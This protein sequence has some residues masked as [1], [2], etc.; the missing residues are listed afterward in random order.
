MEMISPVT[1]ICPT[2][3]VCPQLTLFKGIAYAFPRSEYDADLSDIEVVR[4]WGPQVKFCSKIPSLISYTPASNSSD[5]Q[6]GASI[7]EEALVVKD[8]KKGLDARSSSVDDVE[9][10]LQTTDKGHLKV[11]K[12]TNPKAHPSLLRTPEQIVADYLTKVFHYLENT[13]EFL[14]P[15][16]RTT[17]QVDIVVTV[18]AVED[19]DIIHKSI[20][21]TCMIGLV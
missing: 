9:L 1:P 14:G 3:T 6:W 21:L 5:L 19:L 2:H 20:P 4:D 10:T 15:H 13:F 8:V 11:E 16:L 12:V 18:P 17:V 7:S